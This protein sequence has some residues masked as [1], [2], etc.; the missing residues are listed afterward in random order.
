MK[1]R[2]IPRPARCPTLVAMQ[3]APEVEIAERRR[4]GVRWT[5]ELYI[6]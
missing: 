4:R 3:L 1:K 2:R 5:D 6:G